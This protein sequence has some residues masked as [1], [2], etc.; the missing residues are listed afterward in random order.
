MS[1]MPRS[2]DEFCVA[3]ALPRSTLSKKLFK[4]YDVDNSGQI[5]LKE[6]VIGAKLC[7]G[8]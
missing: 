8:Q 3:F 1:M 7:G 4:M 2:F 6:F 5:E